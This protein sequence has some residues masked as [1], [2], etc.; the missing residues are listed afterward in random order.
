MEIEMNSYDRFIYAIYTVFVLVVHIWV[1]GS[2]GNLLA[3]HDK[4]LMGEIPDR[5]THLEKTV[6]FPFLLLMMV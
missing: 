2:T 3:D 5:C 6:M 1:F 4:N